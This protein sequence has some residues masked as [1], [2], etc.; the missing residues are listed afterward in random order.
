MNEFA[1][2]GLVDG[3]DVE[4]GEFA[5]DADGT[6][7]V[8]LQGFLA[9]AVDGGR[10]A[11]RAGGAQEGRELPGRATGDEFHRAESD[12]FILGR[13]EAG[14][15]HIEDDE[16]RWLSAWSRA[17]NGSASWWKRSWAKSVRM[18]LESFIPAFLS[19][20]PKVGDGAE[21]GVE[22]GVETLG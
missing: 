14:G 17:W 16:V 13:R 20:A 9:D 10:F 18:C 12:D 5:E 7:A 6:V 15:F 2:F 22:C 11:E 21:N 4:A 1:A 19:L 3:E 8:G